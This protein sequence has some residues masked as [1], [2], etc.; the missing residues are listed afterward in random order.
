[1]FVHKRCVFISENP[2]KSSDRNDVQTS[3]KHK[4]DDDSLTE[5]PRKSSKKKKRKK[6][7]RDFEHPTNKKLI[8][9]SED[10]VS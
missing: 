1:M 3:R 6:E 9:D 2:I 5:S 7:E 4:L 10:I 8:S